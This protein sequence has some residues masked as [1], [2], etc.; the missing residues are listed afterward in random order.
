[1]KEGEG[2]EEEDRIRKVEKIEGEDSLGESRDRDQR[3]GEGQKEREEPCLA[4]G[5]ALIGRALIFMYAV[6]SRGFSGTLKSRRT[7]REE[8][9]PKGGE[10]E[11]RK[12]KSY[13]LQAASPFPFC[14]HIYTN[15]ATHRKRQPQARS[16]R[17]REVLG[18]RRGARG[19]GDDDGDDGDDDDDDDDDDDEEPQR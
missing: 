3:K 11:R 10:E 5:A 6:L 4:F 19:G 9:K 12:Q 18:R 2:E 15:M 14:G 1:M 16:E 17:A 7:V 8:E 13:C